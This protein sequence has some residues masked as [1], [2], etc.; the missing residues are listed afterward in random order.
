MKDIS[1]KSTKDLIKL[2]NEKREDLQTFRFGSAGAKVKNV[3]E[4][5]NVRKDIARLMTA[6]TIAAKA[7]GAEKASAKKAA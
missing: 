4:G 2:I 5:R 7:E 1:N 6:L 3:K